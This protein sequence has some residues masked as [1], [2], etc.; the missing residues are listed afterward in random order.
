MEHVLRY[1]LGLCGVDEDASEITDNIGSA[2]R[3]SI[4]GSCVRS[5]G[6]LAAMT[7]LVAMDG[8]NGTA[9]TSAHEGASGEEGQVDVRSEWDE[10]AI[11]TRL[12]GQV[13]AQSDAN[14]SKDTPPPAS[15][16]QMPVSPT[17]DSP[18]LLDD[19]TQVVDPI[20][21]ADFL[22]WIQGDTS[23]TANV[24]S[25]PQNTGNQSNDDA[26]EVAVIQQSTGLDGDDG[27]GV[28]PLSSTNRTTEEET[29]PPSATIDDRA[30]GVKE[31]YLN[32]SYQLSG[33]DPRRKRLT[34]LR[35]GH[36]TVVAVSLS[37]AGLLALTAVFFCW[38]RG[39]CAVKNVGNSGGTRRGKDA[40][41]ESGVG[42]DLVFVMER[43]KRRGGSSS[44]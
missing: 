43:R 34:R 38:F 33:K 25:R 8:L 35:A 36:P 26:T 44:A 28:F 32:E 19:P 7:E 31:T 2:T 9:D 21:Y 10:E 1:I 15:A 16:V 23:E 5:S 11:M 4:E 12:P 14:P 17:N 3:Q 13:V 20:A 39:C 18:S 27:D 24:P 29:R 30:Q 37:I 42:E 41:G 6:M 40:E 22:T